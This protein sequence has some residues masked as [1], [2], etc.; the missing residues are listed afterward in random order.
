MLSVS[1]QLDLY[2]NLRLN[3]SSAM[4]RHRIQYC[5]AGVSR[6]L[7]QFFT[8]DHLDRFGLQAGRFR[9]TTERRNTNAITKH[10]PQRSHQP[11]CGRSSACRLTGPP[12]ARAAPNT[13]G[14]AGAIAI[15]GAP[16]IGGPGGGEML[17]AGQRA[18][19]SGVVLQAEAEALLSRQWW[20]RG[21]IKDGN[22]RRNFD[23]GWMT[24]WP[25]T[26]AAGGGGGGAPAQ[27]RPRSV[28][29]NRSTCPSKAPSARA[30]MS[31][32]GPRP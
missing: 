19:H 16:Q 8:T 7:T 2:R 1:I 18:S 23:R 4:K 24:V 11:E 20:S 22:P 32:G 17:L 12:T 27:H 25:P 10:H 13:S 6:W 28:L 15:I 21:P 9:L 14:A 30:K 5:F 29:K 26:A 3:N 31:D